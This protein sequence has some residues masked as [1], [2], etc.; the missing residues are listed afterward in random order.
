MKQQKN[1]HAGFSSA[2]FQTA[3]DFCVG[4]KPEQSTTAQEKCDSRRFAEIRG[5]FNLIVLKHPIYDID[6]HQKNRIISRF[7]RITI[8]QCQSS[9]PVLLI[10]MYVLSIF[11]EGKRRTPMPISLI[12]L[13][14]HTCPQK[15]S[16]LLNHFQQSII[17]ERIF[18]SKQMQRGMRLMQ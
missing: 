10:T 18:V 5:W 7:P 15:L 13:Q 4:D 11:L 17:V 9:L 16:Y 2:F 14:G 12:F 3:C 1:P 8:Q 6:V